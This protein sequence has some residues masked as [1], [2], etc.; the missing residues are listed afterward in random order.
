LDIIFN[1][2]W[3]YNVPVGRAEK[4]GQLLKDAQK[5][6]AIKRKGGGCNEEL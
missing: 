1:S 6:W 5:S 2:I 4:M 3:H